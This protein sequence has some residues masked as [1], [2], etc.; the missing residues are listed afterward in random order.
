MNKDKLFRCGDGNSFGF[1]GSSSSGSSP[2]KNKNNVSKLK[3]AFSEAAD[4]PRVSRVFD[5]DIKK[6]F[7]PHG[8]VVK[9]EATVFNETIDE[10][11]AA[12]L[13]DPNSPDH[14]DGVMTLT[15]AYHI[16]RDKAEKANGVQHSFTEIGTSITRLNGFSAAKYVIA[17]MALKE[18]WDNPPQDMIVTEIMPSNGPSLHTYTSSLGW[19]AVA[20]KEQQKEL[21]DLANE[22][23]APE[24]QGNAT[25]WFMLASG[26]LQKSA[27]I[28][29]SSLTPD[30]HGNYDLGNAQLYNK[31]TGATIDM[32]LSALEGVG[33]TYERLQEIANGTT[34]RATL[35][36][37][38]P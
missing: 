27:Q 25:K 18:W 29:L 11:R 33:L 37:L 4:R 36:K 35:A 13:Y 1:S 23:I 2:Q 34:N 10:G 19:E 22:N 5:P 7:D 16:Y 15:M 12:F 32:D 6:T 28:I 26:T 38:K 30:V 21:H 31:R 8:Y 3:L 24:D 17:A 9:R 14:D 20:T